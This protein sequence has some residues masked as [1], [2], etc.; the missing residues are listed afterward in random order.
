MDKRA[1]VHQLKKQVDT[2][3]EAKASWYVS[4]Y[5]P[6]G[7]LRTRSCGPGKI[8]Q[9]AANKLADTIHSQLVTGTYVSAVKRDWTE[10]RKKYEKDIVGLLHGKSK[11]SVEDT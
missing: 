9:T 1:W 8:G 5:D 10:F 7:I 6:E 3:G 4:H 2:R 11:R